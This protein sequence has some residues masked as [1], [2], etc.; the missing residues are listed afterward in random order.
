MERNEELFQERWCESSH[1]M[2]TLAEILLATMLFF[3]LKHA[4]FQNFLSFKNFN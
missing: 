1:I 3:Y 4:I 2:F